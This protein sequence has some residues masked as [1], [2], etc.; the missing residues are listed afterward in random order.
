MLSIFCLIAAL[1]LDRL[2]GDPRR[3]HPLAGFGQVAMWLERRIYAPQRLRGALA[4]MLLLVAPATVAAQLAALPVAGPLFSVL[5]LYF[6]L[7]QRSLAEHAQRV[8]DA[9]HG[10]DL[11]LAR[12][13]VG[14]LVSR[15]TAAMLPADVARAGVES[16]LENGNDAVFG[17]L[18][19]FIVAGAPGALLYR[20]A[21][22]LDAMWGYR[23]LRYRYFGW[24]AARFDDLLNLIPARLTAL[25]Y[26]ALGHAGQALACW[27]SQARHWDSPNAG[28]VMAAGAGSLGV[29]LGGPASY[30]G[31]LEVRP[32]LGNGPDATAAD[33]ERALALVRRGVGVWLAAALLG[34]WLLA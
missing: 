24:A 7:G 25:T 33:I 5:I 22:T 21:N 30:H 3:W 34:G 8:A 26:A 14:M 11:A 1:L 20:L 19:W 27:R 23:N 2:L 31:Q 13:Q 12:E 4:V 9:L 16:V 28:P 10:G 18:F 32:S 15:D 6:T 17:A 29:S